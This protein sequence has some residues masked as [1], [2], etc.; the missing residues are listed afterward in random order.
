M[1]WQGLACG[2]RGYESARKRELTLP[3]PG[4]GTSGLEKR[5][6]D[7]RQQVMA[8]TLLLGR[9]VQTEAASTKEVTSPWVGQW[10][11]EGRGYSVATNGDLSQAQVWPSESPRSQGY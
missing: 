5:A 1:G 3:G 11:L 9:Q 7:Q 10:A 8:L 6:Q 2:W 4:L